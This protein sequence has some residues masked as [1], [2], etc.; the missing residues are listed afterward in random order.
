MSSRT[1]SYIV[2]CFTIVVLAATPIFY[3]GQSVYPYTFP[4]ILFFQMAVE[5]VFFLWVALALSDARFRIPLTPLVKALMLFMGVLVVT[6]IL[7]VDPSRSF[8]STQERALGVTAFLHCAALFV[9]IASILRALPSRPLLYSS[10]ASALVVVATQVAQLKV[11]NLLLEENAGLRPGS[12]F[13]NPS[14][15]AG[16]V[17]FF[18]FFAVYA[19]AVLY[20]KES[21]AHGRARGVKILCAILL[22][23]VF[24]YSLFLTQ[25]RGAMLGLIAGILV[26]LGFFAYKPPPLR[27]A[28]LSSRALYAAL[29]AVILV[30]GSVFWITRQNSLWQHVPGLSRFQNISL[31]DPTL[32]PRK[33]A[34]TAAWQGFLERPLTGWGWENFNIVFN[35]HYDPK[36]LEVNYGETRFDKPHNVYLELLVTGGLPLFLSYLALIG[37][38]VYESLKSNDR[39]LSAVA[40]AASAAYLVQN[41]FLFDTL[42]AAMLFFTLLGIVDARYGPVSGSREADA[43]AAKK[44]NPLGIFSARGRA[45]AAG[46]SAA[47]AFLLLYVLNVRSMQAAHDEF[48]GF[49]NFINKRPSQ[50]IE[51]FKRAIAASTPYAWALKREYAIAVAEAHFYNPDLVSRDE[52]ARAIAAM[53]EVTREHPL[54]AYNHYSLIDLYNQTSDVDPS[55]LDRAEQEGRIALQ[56]SPN[57]QEVLF[58]LAK[59]KTLKHDGEAAIALLEEA[60]ALDPNV[61]DTQFYY[62]LLL[63]NN[64]RP[65]EGYAHMKKAIAMG[66]P[67]RTP[68]EP[69]VTANFFAEHGHLQEAVGLYETSLR[70]RD[71]PETK[72]KLAMAYYLTGDKPAAREQ[73]RGVMKSLDIT[74]LSAYQDFL[75]IL[76]DLGL[77]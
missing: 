7:G 66:R 49:K 69:R 35:A 31:D 14:F 21:P 76:R 52:A 22:L 43:D 70:M 42:G 34:L 11:G 4:K 19:L 16:Y 3:L 44:R 51:S 6:A 77:Q 64:Q 37:A 33:V 24:T 47:V 9:V 10:L 53:E 56:L 27:F 25:T 5:L 2:Y 73:F 30:F 17:L 62:G 63:Y 71:D 68:Y 74:K 41:F 18:I 13:G 58:S 8:W 23:G 38:L 46:A 54:D 48:M 28:L 45:W 15:L 72:L 50:A 29:L 61:L 59:T 55:Y 1:L 39:L 75:P 32:Y 60:L 36:I 57:R 20:K 12:F 65:E 26:L 40:L 67:W